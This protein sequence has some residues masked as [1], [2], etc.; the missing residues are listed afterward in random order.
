MSLTPLQF[1]VLELAH[2]HKRSHI[3]SALTAVPILDEIYSKRMPD[4]PVILSA[5]HAFLGLACVLE[6]HFRHLDAED[7]IR[8]H[9]VHPTKN[10]EDGVYCSTGHLGHGITIAAGR[11]LADRSKN[12][13]VYTTDGECASGKV[14]AAISFASR[15]NLTNLRVFCGW[16]G[17]GAYRNSTPETKD[18][19]DGFGFP[20][21]W[22]NTRIDD[23][24]I[25][26]LKKQDAHYYQMTE[27][28][29]EWVVTTS[30]PD[31]GGVGWYTHQASAWQQ[32][33]QVQCER[34]FEARN[35][36][37]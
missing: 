23:L 2:K 8:R 9:G 1:R 13:W 3:G 6:K 37:L 19:L 16:N 14:Y 15:F 26:F 32:P 18:A 27:K 36:P 34:C 29:W 33:E 28:D 12:V 30:C 22:R 11:A 31:C 5:G 17:F 7:L 20:I 25:P 21:E 24:D 10:V 4:E 35:F